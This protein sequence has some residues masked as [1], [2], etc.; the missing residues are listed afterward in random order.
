[1]KTFKFLQT[2]FYQIAMGFAYVVEGLNTQKTAFEGFVR[3]IKSEVDPDSANL[4]FDGETQVTEY[5]EAIRAE[6]SDPALVDAFV[7]LIEPKLN[8]S[9][10][11][12]LIAR[13][14]ENWKA[15]DPYF[16]YSVVSNG[17]IVFPYVP[18]FQ[19]FGDRFIGQILETFVTN[20]YNGRTA[21]ETLNSI[22]TDKDQM[23][24]L[25]GIM[26]ND[27]IAI[28]KYTRIL[29]AKAKEFRASTDRVLLEAGFRRAPSFETAQLAAK[30]ALDAGWQGTSH[31]DMLMDGSADTPQVGGTMAHSFIMC[32]ED[33]REAYKA[34]DRIF[35]GTTMLID[36]YDVI[37]AANMLKEMMDSG[38]ITA[39]NEVR[40]DSDPL[41][42]YTVKVAEIFEG[43]GV[44]VYV[45]GDMSVERF[46][47]FKEIDLPYTKAMAGTKFCYSDETVARLNC[48]FVYKLVQFVND[49]GEVV[50]PEKKATGKKNYPGLKSC[51]YDEQTNVLT[52]DCSGKSMGFQNIEKMPATATV[53]FV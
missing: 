13:F 35:P 42:E 3:N 28:G 30:I 49:K 36:T 48:G 2:D 31:V 29:E 27:P 9:N 16:E 40:I 38:E 10:K 15:I 51:S 11:A 33:E 34:W 22:D 1:M 32:F 43:T 52:V 12:E 46:G 25:T 8:G 23:D 26:T 37:N 7:E 39:P 14:R 47:Y 19:Y 6:L 41:E 5:I 21:L 50:R 17:T 45:S 18:V 20:I 53:K 44:G 24:F 4:V